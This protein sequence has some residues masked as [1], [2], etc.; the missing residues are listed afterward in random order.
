VPIE[1]ICP[2]ISSKQSGEAC[3][4]AHSDVYVAELAFYQN[5]KQAAKRGV[6]GTDTIYDDLKTRFPVARKPSHPQTRHPK[7]A[8]N[9]ESP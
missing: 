5:V 3:T 8:G 4:L 7:T 2:G 9:S 6:P 1:I